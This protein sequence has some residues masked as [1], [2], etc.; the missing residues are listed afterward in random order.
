MT[1]L[2]LMTTNYVYLT[3]EC[4]ELTDDER[5]AEV[6]AKAHLFFWPSELSIQQFQSL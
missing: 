5:Q 4:E 2:Y 3:M 1:F 6:M